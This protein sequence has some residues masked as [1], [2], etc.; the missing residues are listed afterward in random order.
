MKQKAGPVAIVLA[1]LALAGLMFAMYRH[2][3]PPQPP[4]DMDNPSG[5]PDYARNFL[6]QQKDQ[7]PSVP[8]PGSSSG[9]PG[10]SM[11]GGGQ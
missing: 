10:G 8:Q 9:L 7:K 11:G 4:N 1:V 6:K 5:M 2:Y 3:N